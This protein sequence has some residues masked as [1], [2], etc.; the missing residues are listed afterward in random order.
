MHRA[1]LCQPFGAS[2][3][4]SSL[5]VQVYDAAQQA[6]LEQQAAAAASKQAAARRGAQKRHRPFRY[7]QLPI[8]MAHAQVSCMACT[9][10]PHCWCTQ[11]KLHAVQATVEV[12][13]TTC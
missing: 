12:V 4:H 6:Q 13:R 8:N 1:N 7:I 5:A 11:R 2:D 3:N 10:F 9:A